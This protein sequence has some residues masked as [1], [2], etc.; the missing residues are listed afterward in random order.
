MVI[1]PA[2]LLSPDIKIKCTVVKH[3]PSLVGV[4]LVFIPGGNVNSESKWRCQHLPT[5]W[6][7]CCAVFTMVPHLLLVLE[8]FHFL[9]LFMTFV[10]HLS[11][12]LFFP[13][14]PEFCFPFCTFVLDSALVFSSVSPERWRGRAKFASAPLGAAL[15]QEF[16]SVPSFHVYLWHW[17][18]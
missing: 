9:A 16:S 18:L 1:L 14:R 6:D 11:P 4:F 10:V 7:R 15:P 3:F 5:L 8:I 12:F 2:L 13:R 17:V